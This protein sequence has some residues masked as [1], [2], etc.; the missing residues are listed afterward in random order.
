MLYRV[1]K[2]A[3][4]TFCAGICYWTDTA[5]RQGNSPYHPASRALKLIFIK[6][7]DVIII[8]DDVI[9]TF[10]DRYYAKLIS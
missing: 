6:S 4:Y 1:Q 5:Y 3:P 2:T 10:D 8:S 7:D 9:I